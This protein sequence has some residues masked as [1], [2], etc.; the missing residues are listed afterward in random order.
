MQLFLS[1]EHS[2]A[3]ARLLTAGLGISMLHVSGNRKAQR[4]EE[5][6]KN[7]QFVSSQNTWN[8]Y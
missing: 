1:F 5:R 6:W 4:E 3:I 7:D 2:E 8:S